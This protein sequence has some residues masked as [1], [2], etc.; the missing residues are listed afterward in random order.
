[1]FL[2]CFAVFLLC[3]AVFLLCFCC[4]FAVFLLCF[5]CVLLCVFAVFNFNVIGQVSLRGAQ[6]ARF[7][8]I[9]LQLLRTFFAKRNSNIYRERWEYFMYFKSFF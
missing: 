7:E 3:F 6:H 9:S 5:C 8:Y 4:V 2:L 1:M